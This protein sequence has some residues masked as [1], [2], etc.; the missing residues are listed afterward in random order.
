MTEKQKMMKQLRED[1]S[2]VGNVLTAI[3]DETR[4]LI[5]KVL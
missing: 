4:Q 5:L 2:N 1:F 3:G